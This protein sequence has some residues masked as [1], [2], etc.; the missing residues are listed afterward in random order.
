MNH[1]FDRIITRLRALAILQQIT[2][3]LDIF[4]Y[5]I[6]FQTFT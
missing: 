5:Y 4:Y 3:K 6:D 1:I 2:G